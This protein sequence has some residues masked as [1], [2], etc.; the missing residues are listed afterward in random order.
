[1]TRE[2]NMV[3]VGSR[4]GN[5]VDDSNEENS[6]LHVGKRDNVVDDIS[7]YNIVDESSK[8]SMVHDSKRDTRGV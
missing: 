1:M 6:L 3:S 5:M 2:D 7:Q 8:Y 4:G